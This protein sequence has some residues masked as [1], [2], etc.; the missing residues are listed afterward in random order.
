MMESH[1]LRA[2]TRG[3]FE[4]RIYEHQAPGSSLPRILQNTYFIYHH[5]KAHFSFETITIARE[6]AR[7][8]FI[9]SGVKPNIAKPILPSRLRLRR[10]N[11]AIHCLTSCHAAVCKL[12]SNIVRRNLSS[13]CCAYSRR[14]PKKLPCATPI[15]RSRLL[16]DVRLCNGLDIFCERNVLVHI[17]Q[18]D[19]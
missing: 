11:Q 13:R 12:H 14:A 8:R 16:N 9:G 10:L 4:F 19:G 1:V 7:P 3:D 5:R 2:A 15:Q 6:P 17:H 18:G